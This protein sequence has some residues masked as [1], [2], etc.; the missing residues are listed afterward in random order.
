MSWEAHY[1]VCNNPDVLAGLSDEKK[2]SE[3]CTGSMVIT[4]EVISA[5]VLFHH[6]QT[7]LHTFDLS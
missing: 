2:R 5:F 7:N 3:K 6:I 4:K 1:I